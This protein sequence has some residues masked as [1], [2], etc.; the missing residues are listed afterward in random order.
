MKKPGG[1]TQLSRSDL[2]RL[3]AVLTQES[4]Q[5]VVTEATLAAAGSSC[6]RL[7]SELIGFPRNAATYAI[8]VALAERQAASGAKLD[9]V[10]TGPDPRVSTARYTANVVRELFASAQKSVLIAG[11]SFDHGT[12]I[13]EPL[14]AAMRDREVTASLFLDIPTNEF[15]AEPQ[16]YVKQFV[17]KML[18]KNWP[19]GDPHPDVYYYPPTIVN[20]PYASL[21]HATS[22]SAC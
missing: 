16:Q 9:L 18:K 4:T 13:F 10:W 22:R 3:R 14:H 12:D 15:G 17:A 21:K 19:F 5:P 7:A 20:D 8:D 1:L 6:A 11:Y 2:E